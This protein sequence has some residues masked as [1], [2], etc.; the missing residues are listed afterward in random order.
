[1]VL[2]SVLLILILSYQISLHLLVIL[3]MQKICIWI[4]RSGEWNL[5]SMEV[6]FG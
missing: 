1:M 3:I 4:Q 6:N 5:H 2:H